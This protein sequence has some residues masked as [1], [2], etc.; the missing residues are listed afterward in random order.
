MRTKD[1]Q[2]PDAQDGLNG[3]GEG[4]GLNNPEFVYRTF[5]KEK[6]L[7]EVDRVGKFEDEYGY[8]KVKETKTKTVM[9]C[10][11]ALHEQRRDAAFKASEEASYGTSGTA[12]AGDGFK[13]HM[14]T[15]EI[16]RHGLD[17]D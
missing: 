6:L 8:V 10:P 14:D 11:K 15:V 1:E 12:E 9:A 17:D 7:E 13:V 2:R 16:E 5:S 3:K 4:P